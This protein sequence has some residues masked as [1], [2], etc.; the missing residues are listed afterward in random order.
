[1]KSDFQ[2]SSDA[3]RQYELQWE[4]TQ[5]FRSIDRNLGRLADHVDPPGGQ[6]L[7]T[8][9]SIKA[10][11]AKIDG[12]V[13]ERDEQP[14]ELATPTKGWYSVKEAVEFLGSKYKSRTI[15]QACN[16][17][18]IQNVKKVGKAWR[19]QQGELEQIR[20]EGRLPSLL[21]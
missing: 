15:A 7:A 20:N 18:R 17:G 12:L 1:M 19:I 8:E 3:N 21:K 5:I 14:D 10:L 4:W 11:T 16:E 9:A 2:P 13:A 6:Q